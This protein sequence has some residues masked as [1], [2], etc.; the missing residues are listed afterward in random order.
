MK[1]AKKTSA[2]KST[3]SYDTYPERILKGLQMCSDYS[4]RNVFCNHGKTKI[5]YDKQNGNMIFNNST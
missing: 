5:F 3:V 4:Q 1:N 2:L